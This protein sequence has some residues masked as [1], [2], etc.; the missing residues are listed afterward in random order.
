MKTGVFYQLPCADFQN[1]SA[2]IHE[3]INQVVY[4]DTLGFDNAWL[5]ELHFQSAFSVMSAPLL[6]AASIAQQTDKIKIGNAVNLIPLHHPV[7]L[8]EEIATLDVI[9]NGRAVFGAGRGS[10]PSH[11]EGFGIQSSDTRAQFEESL[12]IILKC[13]SRNN[14]NYK[15]TFYNVTDVN[16]VP[17]PIQKPYPEIYI[18]ANS[19]DSFE[20]AGS[21]N[22][23]I[24]VT[25]MIISTEKVLEGLSHY[26]AVSSECNSVGKTHDVTVNAPIYVYEENDAEKL[27]PIIESVSNYIETLKKIYTSPAAI[28][29][30]KHNPGIQR[31][32]NRY[33]SIDFTDIDREY[34]IFGTAEECVDK[35]LKLKSNLDFDQL[36]GWFNIGGLLSNDQVKS[37]MRLFA[38]RVRPKL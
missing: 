23:N 31:S 17:K 21:L 32:L 19:Q 14:V 6:I 13:W 3:T 38:E 11:L 37:S 10:M 9:S 2:R 5:A 24:L 29:A 34:G 4:A 15:G 8:A 22:H 20:Y 25:P 12:D 28:R 33:N 30:S 1:E 7:R 16:V 36:M 35:I 27:D 18:A 26:R